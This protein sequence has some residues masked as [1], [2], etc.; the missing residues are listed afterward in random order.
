MI[1]DEP[2]VIDNDVQIIQTPGHT[3][4]DITVIVKT[5]CYGTVAVTG[6]FVT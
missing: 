5:K 4:S 2:Y 6:L 3:L 1:S